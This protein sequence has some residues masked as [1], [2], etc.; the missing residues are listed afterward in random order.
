MY[1]K[2]GMYLH[3]KSVFSWGILCGLRDKDLPRKSFLKGLTSSGEA[4]VWMPW[5]PFELNRFT[6]FKLF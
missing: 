4:F 3:D 2:V 6:A 1:S 5:G